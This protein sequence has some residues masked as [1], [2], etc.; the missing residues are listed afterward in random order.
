MATFYFPVHTEESLQAA[1]EYFVVGQWYYSLKSDIV[2]LFNS[3]ERTINKGT[4]SGVEVDYSLAIM[5]I[6]EWMPVDGIFAE[7][8]LSRLLEDKRKIITQSY[9]K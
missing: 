2:A 6:D 9:G 8:Y 1:K 3:T 4:W 5:D 7:A